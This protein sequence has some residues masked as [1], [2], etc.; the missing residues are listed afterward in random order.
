MRS[1]KLGGALAAQ[2]RVLCVFPRGGRLNLVQVSVAFLAC[3]LGAHEL[4]IWVV[5]VLLFQRDAAWLDDPNI[6]ILSSLETFLLFDLFLRDQLRLEN[7][8]AV[9]SVLIR[10]TIS[11]PEVVTIGTFIEL[12]CVWASWGLQSLHCSLQ[13]CLLLPFQRFAIYLL[14][15]D[16]LPLLNV[17]LVQDVVAEGGLSWRVG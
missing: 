3:G 4:L 5:A 7:I 17:H 9:V 8:I 11:K 14:E 13:I 12:M 15:D 6:S 2:T 1:H 16:V 10:E